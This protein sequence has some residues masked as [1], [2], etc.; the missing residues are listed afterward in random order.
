[1]RNQTGRWR[2]R[3]GFTFLEIMFVVVII[4]ILLGVAVTNYTNKS[5]KARINSTKLQ[6]DN[7]HS[8]LAQFEM[9][10]GRFPDTREGLQALLVRP[11]NVSEQSWE[12]PYLTLR[13]DAEQPT[14]VWGNP[15]A[16]RAPG[17]K[18]RDYDL[19][20]W[21]PDGRD[22]TEDDITG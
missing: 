13:G 18:N 11:A 9:H 5:N 10:V 17:E 21:G 22:G 12:G 20:S 7:I 6:L 16:Y 15:L 1:M 8:A 14:D 19:W 3:Q 2:G 4:G